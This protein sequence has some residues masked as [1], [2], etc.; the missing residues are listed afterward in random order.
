MATVIKQKLLI[1][2]KG[3]EDY[4]T[5]VSNTHVCIKKCDENGLYSIDAQDSEFVFILKEDW[6]DFVKFINSQLKVSK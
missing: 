4:I 1:L 3:N 5:Y 2:S 6:K